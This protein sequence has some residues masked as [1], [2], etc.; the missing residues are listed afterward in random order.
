MDK[1][2]ILIVEDDGYIRDVYQEI[3]QETGF[4]VAIAIDGQEGFVKASEGGYDLILL[5]MMMPKFN[6]LEFLKALKDKPPKKPNGMVV[7]LTNLAH[8]TVIQEA[9]KA[10]AKS[11]LI[12][13]DLTP[14][15][16]VEKVKSFLE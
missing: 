15:Q 1:K 11:F 3:L 8:D 7:L 10:G 16:L 9:L 12:K 5:D 4:E 6:G 13:S 14:D 2:K